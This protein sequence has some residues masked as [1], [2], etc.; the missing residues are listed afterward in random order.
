EAGG[1]K[2]EAGQETAARILPPAS[3]LLPPYEHMNKAEFKESAY[4]ADMTVSST[5]AVVMAA[6][7]L[8]AQ[9]VEVIDLGAGEPDFPTPENVKQAAHRALDQNFTRYTATSG[10]APLRK[11][12]VEL[13]KRDFGTDYDPAQV[14]VTIRGKQAIFNAMATILNPDDEVLIPAPY[15]V[16][17]PEIVHFLRARPVTVDTEANRFLL[18]AEM[19]SEAISPRTK[20]LILNSPNNPT[21]RII[22]PNEFRKIV[23]EAASGSQASIHEMIAE[24]LRRRNWLVPALNDIPGVSCDLPEGAFYVM[25]NIKDLL[26]GRVKNS[27]ELARVLLEEKGVALTAGSAFGIEGYIRISYANSL[28]TIQEGVRR[29]RETAQELRG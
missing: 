19:V 2:Q 10:I 15:W 11:A 27:A 7:R 21:G 26:G 22:P 9:G 6:E 28:E 14:I 29:I 3:W 12:I 23:D 4:V 8:R 13:L 25:P 24:Y 5:L 1:R 16:T 17:F 20:L 18:T